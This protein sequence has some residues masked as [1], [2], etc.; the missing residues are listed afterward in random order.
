MKQHQI[1][2]DETGIVR[3]RFDTAIEVLLAA[4]LLFMPLAFGVVHA[5]SEEIV[6]IF[7]GAIVI[8]FLLKLLCRRDQNLLWA[9]SYVPILLLL[10]LAALQ[11]VPLPARLAGIVSPNTVA[12]KTDLLS[13][14]PNAG[15][16]LKSMTFSFYSNA[17][18]HDLRLILAAFAVF[19]VVLNV[20]RRPRQ[21]KR[22]LMTIALIGGTV[23]VITL[24]H[25]LFGNGKLYW[26][27]ASDNTKGYSGPFVNHSHYGQF[28]N[29]SMGAALGLLLVKLREA[30][31][32]GRTTPLTVFEY[33]FSDSAKT[34][35][36]L[37]AIISLGAATVL[38][39][40]TR[41]GV[42]SMLIAAFLT[43]LLIA[44][45]RS[46]KSHSWI[47]VFMALI[48]FTFI[49]YIG[50]E[51]IVDRLATLRDLRQAGAGRLQ[52]LKDVTV[53][54]SKFPLLGTGL[55]TYSV[56]YP[57]FDSST[58]TNLATHAE[59][60]YAQ[61]AT[62][63]GLIGV[64]LLI[65]LAAIIWFHFFRNIRRAGHPIHSAAY[66]L[67]FGVLAILIHSFSDFGQHLPANLFLSAI[68]CALLIGL[69]NYPKNVLHAAHSPRPKPYRP[70]L[71]SLL[72]IVVVPVWLWALVT[73]DNAR[74]AEAHWKEALSL[75]ETL[76][77]KNRNGTR[78]ECAQLI[79]HTQKALNH[80]PDNVTYCYGL[81]VY[82]WR[83]LGQVIDPY[84]GDIVI[85]DE[86]MPVVYDIVDQL[87]KARL[88]CPTF[89]PTYSIVGQ[90][91]KFVLNDDSGAERIREGFRL[92]P[93]DP[94]AC[95]VAGYLDVT[96]GR[97]E[98]CIGKFERAIELDGSLFRPV[99][100]IYV[101]HLSRP[102]LAISTAGD[103]IGRL[104][105]V[106]GVLE[107]MQYDDLAG[108]VR[109]KVRDLLEEKCSQRDASASALASLGNI[110]RKQQDSEAAIE[111]YRRALVLNHSQIHWRLELARLL[112]KTERIPEAMREARICLQLRP[113]HKAAETL[114]ADLSVH[115]AVF[116]EEN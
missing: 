7:T 28:M 3:F 54:W 72:S 114:V 39:S 74:R 53:A 52:M 68:S 87:H 60:E 116:G 86:S 105:H 82:R 64:S 23:A 10:S 15:Q 91:E 43:T 50:F 62:E 98:D 66:G 47:M 41:G 113:Q 49:L 107:D 95:F 34:L 71:L 31:A 73:A 111:C 51:A 100:N 27:I 12:L 21:V 6:I 79:S 37:V 84:S 30:F 58:I 106:A 70:L 90:I 57:M 2:S 55:G 93:C 96:E 81:S 13:D 29:L 88:I 14:L 103:D 109:E 89:G 67:G 8:C 36:L 45:R 5:W 33:L 24:A 19:A 76:A 80:Q 16:A 9:W 101:N 26:L 42:V 102:H 65:V 110:Y 20:Y 104:S 99:V 69:S 63:T 48:A 18:K 59:N 94:V 44:S 38:I 17:T 35:W 112:A 46:L 40:L 97:D 83:S 25:N 61:A 11:L 92:A 4:L 1:T 108:Q 75:E 22:L 115:P 32:Q 77:Q 78:A 85:P 56:I